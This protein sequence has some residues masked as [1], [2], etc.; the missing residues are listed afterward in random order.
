MNQ[1]LTLKLVKRFPVLYQD[2]YSDMRT[3]CMCWGFSC[4]DGWFDIIWQLSLA[5][6]DELGYS[7]LHKK[8]FI[9]KKNL[10]RKWNDFI[11]KLSPPVVHK[12]KMF[13]KGT[14]EE[15]YRNEIVERGRNKLP[16]LKKL[17]WYPYTGF[18]VN[19][20]KEK[21]GTLS[22]YCN[23]NDRISRLI[24]FAEELSSCTCEVCGKCGKLYTDGW[25][26]TACEEHKR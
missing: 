9:F 4:S 1:E 16:F 10:S 19:Q 12:Y 23:E 26:Y 25:Y 21:F 7:W 2:F 24:R 13:G 8:F 22:Y 3:T 11:Y 20:V 14:K 18:A 15:P 17:I 5:I 6:E